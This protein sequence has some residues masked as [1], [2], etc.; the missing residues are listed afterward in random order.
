MTL[1]DRLRD[2]LRATHGPSSLDADALLASV[3]R[4]HQRQRDRRRTVVALGGTGL[5]LLLPGGVLLTSRRSDGEP[6]DRLEL[7][8]GETGVL[9]GGL[10]RSTGDPSR[11]D[12]LVADQTAFALDLYRALAAEETGNLFFSPHSV[13]T[14]LTMTAAG[15]AGTTL[16]QMRSA[17]R[18]GIPEPA[19]H[20]AAN[21]LD[22]ALAAERTRGERDPEDG[23]PLRLSVTNSLWGQAGFPF[24]Q[25]FLSLLAAQYGAGMQIVDFAAATEEARRAINAWVAE[26]TEDRIPELLGEGVLDTLTRLVLVNAIHFKASWRDPFSMVPDQRFRTPAGMV[27]APA[28]TTRLDTRS[29]HVDGWLAVQVPYV[30]GAHMLILQPDDVDALDAIDSD[31]LAAVDRALR[32]GEVRLT[33]PPFAATSSFR[34]DQRLAA[35]GMPDAFE[36]SAADFSRMGPQGDDLFISAVVHEATITVDE[37]GTEA[38]AATAVVASIVSAEPEV[39]E[40]RIDGSFA[41]LIRDD[42]TGA[43]LF[44]GRVV[45]PTA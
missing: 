26:R 42:A 14:A 20:E 34:L 28:M 16:E 43:V 13:S 25:E 29:A 1:D 7:A 5:A 15:A 44:A 6:T 32:E 37:R 23:E 36:P 19:L 9:G 41:Y 39:R 21:A 8:A 18:L 12:D 3:H 17:L 11:I 45:D 2:E 31:R 38:A 35:L 33:M 27:D 24:Y 10:S 30:G 4:T 40:V 22:Q